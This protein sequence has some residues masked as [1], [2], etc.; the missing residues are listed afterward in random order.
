MRELR[1]DTSDESLWIAIRGDDAGAFKILFD[2]YWSAIF[3]T[4]FSY[5][6]DR[7]VCM[8]IVHDIFLGIWLKRSSLEI[9][10]FYHYLTAAARYQV[11]KRLQQKG[12][13]KIVY[14]DSMRKSSEGAEYR[15]SGFHEATHHEGGGTANNEGEYNLRYRELQ[16][17]VE[18]SL[19]GL[20]ERCREIFL[21]SRKEQL[22]IAEIAEQLGI[23]RRT[24]ENQLTRALQHLRHSLG[25]LHIV[26]ILLGFLGASL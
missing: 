2:R 16:N 18:T 17:T 9:G 10:S 11:Y 26:F 20:P 7:A 8:E 6:H 14:M 25:D 1:P 23:S 3:S 5:L 15:G 13:L 24:V 19:L 4:S 12:A 22:S 21:L